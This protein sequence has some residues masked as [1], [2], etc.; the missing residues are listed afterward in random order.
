MPSYNYYP[1][2]YQQN[3][4]PV[5]QSPTYQQNFPQTSSIVWVQGEAGARAYPVPANT[6]MLLMDS[7][8]ETFFLKSTDASG[9]P[10]PIR[11]YEYAEV[12]STPQ[13]SEDLATKED[14]KKLHK[15][16]DNIMKRKFG[17]EQSIQSDEQ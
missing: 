5:Y 11:I 17:D 16:L 2:T 15:R 7:E 10:Q 6:T 1:A 8:S 12:V 13:V 3:Y 4:V 9:M 14:I